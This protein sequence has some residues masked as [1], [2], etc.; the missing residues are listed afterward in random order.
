[1]KDPRI[2]SRAALMLTAGAPAS[3]RYK[4]TADHLPSDVIPIA[5]APGTDS[6]AG[7]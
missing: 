1:L 6:G 4:L 2:P 5:R 7:P 3:T